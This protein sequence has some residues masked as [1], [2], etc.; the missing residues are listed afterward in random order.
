[1]AVVVARISNCA[2]IS[3]ERSDEREAESGLPLHEKSRCEKCMLAVLLLYLAYH[4]GSS[5]LRPS[6]APGAYARPSTF[7]HHRSRMTPAVF[8]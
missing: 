1:M 2:S 4:P 5:A 6:F 7:S 3:A 8:K